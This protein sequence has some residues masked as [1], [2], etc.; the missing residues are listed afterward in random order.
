MVVEAWL[1]SYAEVTQC[2]SHK[3]DL[4]LDHFPGIHHACDLDKCFLWVVSHGVLLSS[5]EDD[6]GGTIVVR[7]SHF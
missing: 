5:V 1:Q 7:L 2:H 3:G 6:E 4:G